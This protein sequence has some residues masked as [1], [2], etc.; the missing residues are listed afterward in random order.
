MRCRNTHQGALKNLGKDDQLSG[1]LAS[2]GKVRD[3]VRRL[4]LERSALAA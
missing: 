2:I 4:R 3:E 1:V